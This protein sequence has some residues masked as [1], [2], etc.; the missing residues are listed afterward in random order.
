[1]IKFFSLLKTFMK[2]L[3]SAPPI[4]LVS[5]LNLQQKEN[6]LKISKVEEIVN[7]SFDPKLCSITIALVMVMVIA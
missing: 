7:A 6:D 3:K 4:K 5:K 1:M 2:Q